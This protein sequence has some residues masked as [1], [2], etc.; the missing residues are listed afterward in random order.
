MYSHLPYSLHVVT[1]FYCSEDEK[2]IDEDFFSACETP[3]QLPAARWGPFRYLV[4]FGLVIIFVIRYGIIKTL[5]FC[6]YILT[7]CM[8]T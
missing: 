1:V 7:V 5:V 2:Y 8:T 6:A 4:L 3:G